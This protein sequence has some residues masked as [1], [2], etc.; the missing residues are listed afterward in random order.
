MKAFN[1]FKFVTLFFTSVLLISC[2]KE[3]DKAPA[4]D[5]CELLQTNHPN[6]AKYQR[7]ADKFMNA[8]AVG[9]SITIKSPEGVWSFAAG[10]ADL[11][12]D[13]DLTPCHT[14][15]IGSISKTFASVTILKLQEQGKLDIDDKAAKY[16]PEEFGRKIANLDKATV[17]NLLQHTSG[18]P[19]YLGVSGIFDIMNLS[20][21]NRS[22]AESLRTIFGKKAQFEVGT[23]WVYTNANYLLIAMIIEKITGKTAFEA[24]TESVLK[25]LNMQN[26]Y[27]SRKLPST[28]SRGYYDSFNNGVMRDYTEID[29]NAVGGQ[30]MLDGGMVSNATDLANFMEALQTGG[31]LSEESLAEMEAPTNIAIPDVPADLAYIKDYGLGLFKLDVDGVKGI[32]HG[33]NVQSFNCI[34]YY[35]PEKKLSVVIMLNSYSKKLQ[36]VLFD[37]ETIK[38]AF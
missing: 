29:N 3:L 35:F 33:G 9:A 7:I 10:K 6:A 13:T 26:T 15:R 20:V 34:A 19:D 11:T 31:V 21:K 38:M 4:I 14:L 25:P 24:V 30:D 32:G 27:A 22:A 23:S 8:G 16:L 1:R 36:K 5:R 37:K 18:I 12:S 28:L 17:R 2:E